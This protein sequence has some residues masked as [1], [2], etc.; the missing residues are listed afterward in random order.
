[1]HDERDYGG[2]VEVMS[3]SGRSR[4]L[5]SISA[6]QGNGMVAG[7]S[8]TR[9]GSLMRQRLV[10]ASFGGIRIRSDG[11]AGRRCVLDH[12]DAGLIAAFFLPW[13]SCGFLH[14]ADGAAVR[15]GINGFSA[16]LVE[17]CG[18]VGGSRPGGETRIAK[19]TSLGAHLDSRML[20]DHSGSGTRGTP[21]QHAVHAAAPKT[22][23]F[24][25]AAKVH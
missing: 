7:P 19:G 8:C 23:I 25:G 5:L 20:L 24:I 15:P 17:L 21:G 1:M 14:M 6:W 16:G 10:Y 18:R 22:E 4:R 11:R 13:W 12:G 9:C 3:R 2:V